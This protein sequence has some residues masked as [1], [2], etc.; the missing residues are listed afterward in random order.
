[1]VSIIV[2]QAYGRVIGDA[3]SIPW[4]MPADLRHF[5]RLTSGHAVIMGRVTY[6]SILSKLGHPL[7]DRTNIVI[8]RQTSFGASGCTVVHSLDDAIKAA[9]DGEIFVI[10]GANVYKQA[11]PLADRIYRTEVLAEVPGDTVFPALDYADWTELTREAH[12][13]D[14]RN[15]YA[16]NFVTLEKAK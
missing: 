16:Y 11:L 6:Q 2:A 9:G 8:S 5:K 14:D 4:F 10:G 3:N 13:A 7:P 1:M 15:Q 12:P